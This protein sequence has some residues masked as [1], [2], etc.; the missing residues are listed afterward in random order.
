MAL[1]FNAV[2]SPSLLRQTDHPILLIYAFPCFFTIHAAARNRRHD[3]GSPLLFPIGNKKQP[4]LLPCV[5]S[6]LRLNSASPPPSF[7]P[8]PPPIS[9]KAL[10]VQLVPKQRKILPEVALRASPPS[11]RTFKPF[12]CGVPPF[13]KKK[14]FLA[15]R[16]PQV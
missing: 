13:A 7:C 15:R 4:F 14:L 11:H 9:S 1:P 8:Q 6:Y 2:A 5:F 16:L 3:P 10:P 12:P